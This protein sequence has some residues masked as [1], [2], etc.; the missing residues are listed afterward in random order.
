MAA[1]HAQ[2]QEK[3]SHMQAALSDAAALNSERGAAMARAE[4]A[5]TA[6][7]NLE[8]QLR[9]AERVYE[10]VEE[11]RKTASEQLA[12]AEARLSGLQADQARSIRTEGEL[13][14]QLQ[15]LQEQLESKVEQLEQVQQQ[16]QEV[17]QAKADAARS[18][19]RH[20]VQRLSCIAASVLVNRTLVQP[21]IPSSCKL[22]Q[23][24]AGWIFSSVKR[25]D[26][27]A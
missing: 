4:E 25:T 27:C 7:F 1:L 5:T 21:C 9:D 17:Q 11:A 18:V 12:A 15:Q 6:A 8:R 20:G 2:L 22:W 26:D 16:L 3:D 23:L 13:R 14:A 19:C 24:A 10:E